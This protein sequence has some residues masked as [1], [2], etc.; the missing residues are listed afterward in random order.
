MYAQLIVLG[1][2][3]RDPRCWSI[4]DFMRQGTVDLQQTV[5]F[6]PLDLYVLIDYWGCGTARKFCGF[7]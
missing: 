1:R 7:P 6:D 5:M 4:C 3:V 2:N